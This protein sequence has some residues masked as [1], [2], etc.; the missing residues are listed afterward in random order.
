MGEE[1]WFA[2]INNRKPDFE[3]ADWGEYE[4][5]SPELK[6]E[7]TECTGS[8]HVKSSLLR[9]RFKEMIHMITNQAGIVST[10]TIPIPIPIP[11]QYLVTIASS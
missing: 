11:I 1:D 6:D 7:D 10:N 8:R 4:G 3:G 2:H 5:V 9:N